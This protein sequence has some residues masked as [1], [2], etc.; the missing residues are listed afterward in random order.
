MKSAMGDGFAGSSARCQLKMKAS[1]LTGFPEAKVKSGL[2]LK[3]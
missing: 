3:V 2:I 1:A